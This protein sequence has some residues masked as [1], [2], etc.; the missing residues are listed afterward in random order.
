MERGWE[1]NC[2]GDELPLQKCQKTIDVVKTIN[3]MP[4]INETKIDNKCDN[5]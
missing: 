1:G 3:V 5:F 2:L 4:T